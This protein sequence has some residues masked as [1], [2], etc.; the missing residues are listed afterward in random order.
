VLQWLTFTH[1]VQGVIPHL[2]RLIA[3]SQPFP[4]VTYSAAWALANIV[5]ALSNTD[6]LA[7]L[8]Q[9]PWPSMARLLSSTDVCIAQHAWL[10]MQNLAKQTIDTAHA[11]AAMLDWAGP[12]LFTLLSNTL[13]RTLLPETLCC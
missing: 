12:E 8:S 13:S 7:L 11:H 4:E 1:D 6:R 5:H 2:C 10:I 3:P 9:L